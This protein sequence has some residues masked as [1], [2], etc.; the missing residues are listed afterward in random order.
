[1]EILLLVLLWEILLLKSKLNLGRWRIVN[2]LL[3]LLWLLLSQQRR[4]NGPR[5]LN[6]LQY[7]RL[8]LMLFNWI[9]ILLLRSLLCHF[10]EL[11]LRICRGLIWCRIETLC[12]FVEILLLIWLLRSWLL[13]NHHILWVV[14]NWSFLKLTL[15]L[16]TWLVNR[17]WRMR[18]I[19]ISNVLTNGE[20]TLSLNRRRSWILVWLIILGHILRIHVWYL[21]IRYLLLEY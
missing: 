14:C 6:G 20:I 2:R 3:K 4:I 12:L 18:I 5:F 10:T 19:G 21:I 11:K 13:L 17:H 15:S 9:A 16:L 1:L 7:W 8:R